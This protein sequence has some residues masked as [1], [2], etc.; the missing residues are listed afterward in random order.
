[1]NNAEMPSQPSVNRCPTCRNGECP[2]INTT[3]LCRK[4]PKASIDAAKNAIRDILLRGSSARLHCPPRIEEP[5]NMVLYSTSLRGVTPEAA[6]WALHELVKSGKLT[7][8]MRPKPYDGVMFSDG[9]PHRF[10]AEWVEL[11]EEGPAS[12]DSFCVRA[13]ESLGAAD[14]DHIKPPKTKLARVPR[15]E[16][17]I[18]AR[19]ILNGKPKGGGRW[20][21]RKL[22][23]AIECSDGM[24]SK[25]PAWRTYL[26][27]HP[28]R[29]SSSNPLIRR[30]RTSI[31]RIVSTVA[32]DRSDDPSKLA[33]AREQAE[34]AASGL[35][36]L[37]RL[38]S[39][40]REDAEPSPLEPPSPP[41][42]KRRRRAK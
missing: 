26:E 7:A 30:S 42:R 24:I 41:H 10:Q 3:P 34:M 1:M 25:L 16:A 19:E 17:N 27:E 23:K 8:H 31:E 38:I 18:R 11:P 29:A 28:V 6:K 20:T 5:A 36:E 12:P 13:E 2:V 14:Q 40:H 37:K 35:D 4:P 33:E 21:V 32:D 15:K 22:A 39:E 9:A